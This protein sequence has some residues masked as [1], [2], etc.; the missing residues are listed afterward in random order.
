MLLAGVD[1]GGG[2]VD[3]P[4]DAGV[5][6]A[7]VPCHGFEVAGAFHG[8]FGIEP[9]DFGAATGFFFFVAADFIENAGELDA[10]LFVRVIEFG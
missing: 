4:F 6:T 9:D 3:V 2:G 5:A 7:G 1:E 10:E 8:V